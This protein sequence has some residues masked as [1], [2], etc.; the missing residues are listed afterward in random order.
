MTMKTTSTPSPVDD[1]LDELRAL[2]M[3]EDA[4]PA[5]LAIDSPP[6]AQD[7]NG[8]PVTKNDATR[9][10][11]PAYVLAALAVIG[12]IVLTFKGDAIPDVLNL[13]AIGSIGIGGAVTTPRGPKV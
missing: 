6:A 4:L 10:E 7:S 9:P 13:V 12:I 8:I 2:V 5:P 1:K 11:L 3:S